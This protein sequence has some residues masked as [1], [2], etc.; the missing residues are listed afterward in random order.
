MESERIQGQMREL[1]EGKPWL[2]PSVLDILKPVTAAQAAANPVPHVHGIW[3]LLLHLTETQE[4]LMRRLGGDPC[5]GEVPE[6]YWPEVPEPTEDA[7]QAAIET[8]RRNEG[9]LRDA[10]AQRLEKSP[11]EEPIVPGGFSLYDTLHGHCEHT[12]YHVGQMSLMYRT[13]VGRSR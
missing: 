7:W 9:R 12:A 10:A 13:Q 8:F 4:Y 6:E 3:E 2:G 5:Q 1:I 11:L